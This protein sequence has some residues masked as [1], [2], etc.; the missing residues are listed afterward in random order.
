[1]MAIYPKWE[2]SLGRIIPLSGSEKSIASLVWTLHINACI[3]VIWFATDYNRCFNSE[4]SL[5]QSKSIYVCTK[6]YTKFQ[7]KIMLDAKQRNFYRQTQ[8]SKHIHVMFIQRNEFIY[9]KQCLIF[10]FNSIRLVCSMTWRI[11]GKIPEHNTQPNTILYSLNGIKCI[12]EWDESCN[13]RK[14]PQTKMPLVCELSR[15]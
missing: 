15:L 12:K 2:E 8:V 3:E 7:Y 10:T 4:T 11:T 13:T 14:R 6:V 9:G 1:M 5:Y